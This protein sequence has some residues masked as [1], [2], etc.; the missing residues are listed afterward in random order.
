MG[1][2]SALSS[3]AIR[4]MFYKR[5]EAE[6]AA[7]WTRSI[8]HMFDSDQESETY[9]FLGNVPALRAWRGSRTKKEPKAYG[10]TIVNDK[11]EASVEFG[12]DD[13]RRD[14]TPQIRVRIGELA[15]RSAQLPQKVLTTLLTTN[16]PSYDGVAFYGA[17][18]S[19]TNNFSDA[20]VV[21]PTAPTAEEMKRNI[22]RAVQTVMGAK[23][24]EGEPMNEGAK[25]FVVMVPTLWWGPTVGALKDEFTAASQSNTLRSLATMG[26]R[27]TPAL[28]SR[29]PAPTTTGD[30]FVFRT[31]ADQLSLIWQDEV[32]LELEELGEGSDY[33]FWNDAHVFG[34]QRIG[35]G[36]YGAHEMTCRVTLS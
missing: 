14:K 13:I 12:R 27:I 25:D 6:T 23:D 36:G 15:E 31:D 16:G 33:A 19:G 1:T 18:A 2:S 26:M 7:S 5:L 28:N 35:N 20:T 21:D 11:F 34:T 22:L 10:V 24:D 3:R 30:F 4:G 9:K 17:H 32:E 29:L 8:S